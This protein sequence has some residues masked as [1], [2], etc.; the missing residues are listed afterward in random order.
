MPMTVAYHVHGV[1]ALLLR[2]CEKLIGKL[3]HYLAL[4]GDVLATQKL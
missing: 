4:E 3:A 1:C 2:K